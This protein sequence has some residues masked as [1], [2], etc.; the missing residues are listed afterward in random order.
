MYTEENPVRKRKKT[1]WK[2]KLESQA[3][4]QKTGIPSGA[5]FAS[6]SVSRKENA[7]VPPGD[8]TILSSA[9]SR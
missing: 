7:V 1:G 8:P 2:R 9:S 4:V 6:I 5:L 3:F